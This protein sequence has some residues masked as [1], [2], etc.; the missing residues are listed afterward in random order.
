[1]PSAYFLNEKDRD[2]LQ[3]LLAWWKE[4]SANT[5]NRPARPDDDT[6][7]TPETYVAFTPSGGIDPLSLATGLSIEDT[8]GSAD[9]DIYQLVG[10]VGGQLEPAGF[11]QR[12]FNLDASTGVPGDSWVLATRDKYG[13]W[14]VAEAPFSSGTTDELVKNSATD[15][16]ANY[17]VD[18]L[19]VAAATT[20]D[21]VT[22]SM[23]TGSPG[24]DEDSQLSVDVLPSFY[25]TYLQKLSATPG[26]LFF[27]G[28]SSTFSSLVLFLT[29]AVTTNELVWY[30]S[31]WTVPP[32][33]FS[34]A[35]GVDLATV[36]V[37]VVGTSN[38]TSSVVLL[39]ESNT[40][41]VAK[42]RML[43]IRNA[44]TVP[45][46][47]NLWVDTGFD[48]S[49]GAQSGSLTGNVFR[50]MLASGDHLIFVQGHPP[51]VLDSTGRRKVVIS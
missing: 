30:I 49:G 29:G 8:P 15:T 27:R 3:A 26:A 13:T 22:I 17:L 46:I 50:L 4:Q 25:N 32:G 11:A 51:V 43:V 18:K 2:T 7:F 16:T 24:G 20:T 19:V 28:E 23:V 45:S 6:L 31:Y 10:G 34:S 39:D 38:G 42:V 14:F 48:A 40:S 21:I 35:P 47:V 9:C 5:R 36:P 41:T 1:M 12:V 33:S 44:D 37:S